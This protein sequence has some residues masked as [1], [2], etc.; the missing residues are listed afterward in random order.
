MDSVMVNIHNGHNRDHH[1]TITPFHCIWPEQRVRDTILLVIVESMG[2]NI[3]AIE[4]FEL[5]ATS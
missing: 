2:R 1:T 4:P 3:A 5:A